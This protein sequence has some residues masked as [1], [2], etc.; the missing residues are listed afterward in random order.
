MNWIQLI[1]SA[2]AVLITGFLLPGVEVGLIA[3]FIV[4]IGLAFANT[5]VMPIMA[6]LGLP[7]TVLVVGIFTHVMNAVF[8][9]IL[10]ALLRNLAS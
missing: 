2:G 8:V 10:S 1:I 9:L 4:A 3:A 5:F 7:T 6:A